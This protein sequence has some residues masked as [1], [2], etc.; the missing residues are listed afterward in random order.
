MPNDFEA[1]CDDFYVNLR[2]G[3]QM[4]LPHQRETLLHFFEQVQKSFPEMTRFRRCDQNEYTIEE[5]RERESYRWLSVESQR[6]S[7]GHVNPP[8]IEEAMRLHAA[9]LEHAP[10][11]LGL[12]P[13]EI[14]YVDVLYGFDL[15]FAGN[16]D[17]I[18]AE[19]LF[20]ESPLA[21]LLEEPGARPMDFQP[22]ITIALSDDYR[23]QAR[24]DV[25]TRTTNYQVRTGDYGGESISVYLILRKFWGD[26]PK[27][28][29]E[30]TVKALADRAHSMAETYVV[31]RVVQPIRAAIVSRS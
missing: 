28:S 8:S 9:V 3:T 25:V 5:S 7:S 10:Y 27:A 11:A 26:R 24:V 1:V 15:D 29:L 21:S 4:N 19:S 17:E 18:V 23:M 13:V 14:D 2:I 6:L 12:S 30:E 20:A 31:P 16:H 22:T